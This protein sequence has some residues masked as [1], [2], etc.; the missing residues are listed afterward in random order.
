MGFEIGQPGFTFQLC[1]LWQC[2]SPAGFQCSALYSSHDPCSAPVTS[3]GL[4]VY[5]EHT[6]PKSLLSEIRVSLRMLYLYF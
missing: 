1:D 5:A 6:F 3:A 4:Q 2:L